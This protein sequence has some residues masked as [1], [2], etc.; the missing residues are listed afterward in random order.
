MSA[1]LYSSSGPECCSGSLMYPIK[2]E[3]HVQQHGAQ[4]TLGEARF[5]LI[6]DGSHAKRYGAHG[7]LG[8]TPFHPIK[9]GSRAQQ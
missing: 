8:E 7:S 4:G 3:P 9:N 2:H 6:R 1:T 5:Y